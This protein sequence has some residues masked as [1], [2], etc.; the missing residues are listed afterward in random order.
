MLDAGIVDQHIDRT[1][2]GYRRVD[3]GL[4][5][6]AVSEVSMDEVSIEAIGFALAGLGIDISHDQPVVSR[7]QSFS[8]GEADTAGS[9]GNNSNFL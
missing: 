8:D 5:G 4:A 6:R 9:T 2:L 3:Q 7:G 1:E